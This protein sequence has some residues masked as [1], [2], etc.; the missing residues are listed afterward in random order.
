[1]F[2]EVENVAVVAHELK[3][4]LCLMRQ[5]ALSLELTDDTSR[6]QKLQTQLVQVSNR[7]LRQVEDLTRTAR[8]EDGLFVMEPVSVRGICDAVLRE[9]SPLFSVEKRQIRTSY[10]NKTRLASANHDLL[11]S[12]VYNLCTNALRYSDQSL[13]SQLQIS[14]HQNHIRISVRDY[15]PALPAS[16]WRELHSGSLARPVNIAMR[17]GSS[18]LGLYI[19]S[20][21][22]DQ[23]HGRLGVIRHRDG[24]SF[25]IDLL[26]S[27]QAMLPI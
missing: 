6:R 25:F 12:V 8:L 20:R 5:L 14:D 15:G 22:A 4:P 1:M 2:K 3:T 17:P 26:P 7:A 16:I 11:Y 13:S 24:T 19:A 9:I 18:G 21:F 10:L 23:M 27:K